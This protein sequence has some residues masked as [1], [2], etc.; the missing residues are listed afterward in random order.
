[1]GQLAQ[2]DLS[3]VIDGLGRK[4]EIGKMSAAV[5]VFKD[6]MIEAD[7]LKAEQE[8]AQKKAAERSAQ[9]DQL[10]KD[11]DTRVQGVVQTVASQA[12]QMETSAQSLSATAEESTK[13]ASAVAA[14][15]E[16]S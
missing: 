10:T 1:M 5:Q 2:H 6:S 13:Q 15:S 11:F 4:D 3:T 14:A 8:K 12:T 16:Q 7:G 9:I